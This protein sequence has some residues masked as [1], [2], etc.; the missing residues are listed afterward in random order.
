MTTNNQDNHRE[1]S[2]VPLCI[3]AI[4]QTE[5]TQ[6]RSENTRDISMKGIFIVTDHPVPLRTLCEITL[7]LKGQENPIKVEIRGMVVRSTDEGIG[8]QFTELALEAYDHLQ[9][10]VK[11]N[12]PDP[13]QV[14]QEFKEHLGLKKR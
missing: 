6:V 9:N 7:V 10:M 13:D 8:L 5:E 4:V 1:F 12:S 3:E 2:R 14:E 11:L